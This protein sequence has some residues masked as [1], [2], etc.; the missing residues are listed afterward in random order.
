M[1]PVPL[2]LMVRLLPVAVPMH[3]PCLLEIV[4]PFK[5]RTKV[6]SAGISTVF[7]SSTS[8]SIVTVAPLFASANASARSAT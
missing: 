7:A 1:P 8:T 3:V 2:S 5:S 6:V 4:Y